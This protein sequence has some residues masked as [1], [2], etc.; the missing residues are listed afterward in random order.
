V[1]GLR[2]IL[3][4][5]QPIADHHETHEDGGGD[6]LNVDNLHG[7]LY[8]KQKP[9]THG[10]EAHDPNYSPYPHS[11]VYHSVPYMSVP[12]ALYLRDVDAPPITYIN[13][14][15]QGTPLSA[16]LPTGYLQEGDVLFLEAY[17]TA[18]L[19]DGGIVQAELKVRHNGGS[20]QTLATIPA[21]DIPSD[22]DNPVWITIRGV[23]PVFVE[24]SALVLQ[25]VID[26]DFFRALAEL[27]PFWFRLRNNYSTH[28]I[29]STDALDIRLL[30]TTPGGA[31]NYAY[32][33]YAAL[34]RGRPNHPE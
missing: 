21:I 8:N 33:S 24:E 3:A 23:I 19:P 14:A 34:G 4:D 9:Q 22:P 28:P 29:L 6:E 1:Q 12:A 31:G 30:F 27:T 26:A 18:L 20:W 11:N 15:T 13:G 5:G 10:N 7:V 25:P 17:A 16:S 2:G 32:F